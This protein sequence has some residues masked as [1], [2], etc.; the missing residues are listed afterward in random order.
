MEVP[1]SKFETGEAVDGGELF[2]FYSFGRDGVSSLHDA[3]LWM[4]HEARPALLRVAMNSALFEGN[5]T[6]IGLLAGMAIRGRDEAE[7]AKPPHPEAAALFADIFNAAATY[8]G[9]GSLGV[10]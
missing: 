9:R 8:K 6:M 1:A 4:L 5:L 2:T 10:S 7:A 3:T